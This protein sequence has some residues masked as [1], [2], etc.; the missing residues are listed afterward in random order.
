MKGK[1]TALK[2]IGLILALLGIVIGVLGAVFGL[3]KYRINP[4]D[5]RNS[6]VWIK[7]TLSVPELKAEGAWAGT[8]WAVGT[9]GQDVKYIITNGHVVEQAY[10]WP[11]GLDDP[12]DYEAKNGVSFE[13]ALKDKTGKTLKELKMKAEIRVYFSQSSNDYSIPEVVYFS[14]PSEKDI[15]I[16]K[17]E[18]PTSKR[19]ALLVKDSDQVQVG[20][21]VTALGFPGVSD[22]VQDP[23][24]INHGVEDV[25]V[26]KG[27]VSKRVKPNGRDY[28]TFQ[29]DVSINH[30]NSGGPLVDKNGYVIGMNTLGNAKDSNMNYA[31]V[32]NEILTVLDSE[33]ISYKTTALKNPALL[34]L[35]AVGIFFL[36][37][38]IIMLVIPTGKKT[39]A[40]GA[41]TGAA[42]GMG[43]APQ[44][45]Q[46]GVNPYA[47]QQ[48]P[49]A[50]GYPQ[51]SAAPVAAAGVQ[52]QAAP[53]QAAVQSQGRPILKCLKGQFAGK[54]F[55][56]SRGK[57]VLGRDPASCNLVFNKE[58]PGISSKH[59]SMSYDAASGSFLLTDLGSSYGTYT[60]NGKKLEPNV[61]ERLAAGDSF[62][63]AD[64]NV[65]FQ[66]NKE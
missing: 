34:S 40:A 14:G 5:A 11:K 42:A 55:D 65:K 17:L 53:Q 52:T 30:G 1:F 15:A 33:R 45:P 60:G 13:K 36:A 49:V 39:A 48:R 8:G 10:A 35:I 54:A 12:F 59:C 4:A 58:T 62:Y 29:M 37:G 24:T 47:A 19:I 50:Q 46:A 63:L 64:E 38:G 26:T 3:Q 32:S 18:E 9:P 66:I 25:T 28:D 2:V 56:L 6:V 27:I 16:L 20:D 23:E 57:V 61:P 44:Q 21:E 22:N 31:I 7:E 41:V 43:A 51:Q